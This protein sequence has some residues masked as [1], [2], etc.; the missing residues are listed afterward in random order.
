MRARRRR[1]R[2]AE[3]GHCQKACGWNTMAGGNT[4]VGS[5]MGADAAKRVIGMSLGAAALLAALPVFA[6]RSENWAWC[7]DQDNAF[8]PDV[9]ING[10]TALIESGTQSPQN[11][12]VVF[13]NRGIA[14]RA[15]GDLDR[16]IADYTEAIRLDP[17]YDV[18]YQNRGRSYFAKRDYDH[19]I[20]DYDQALRINPRYRFA[21]V[22]RGLAYFAKHDAA[23]AVADYSEAVKIDPTFA[24]A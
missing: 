18:A 2:M 8:A 13:N 3:G 1:P 14:Y 5:M 17:N 12:P 21:Y 9:S 19:A 11:I 23:R 16:A 10:C 6:Q 7:E 22:N 4:A 24:Y 20:A 15:K